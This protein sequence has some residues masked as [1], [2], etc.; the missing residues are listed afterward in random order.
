[1]ICREPN[2]LQIMAL[3]SFPSGQARQ[4]QGDRKA[5]FGPSNQTRPQ[6]SHKTNGSICYRRI[7]IALLTLTYSS[8]DQRL[9]EFLFFVCLL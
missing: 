5:D 2:G 8:S 6:I 1:M 3:T 9:H 7:D 4:G